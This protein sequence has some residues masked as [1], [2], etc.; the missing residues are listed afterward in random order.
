MLSSRESYLNLGYIRE[1]CF[2]RAWSGLS[3]KMPSIIGIAAVEAAAGSK[4]PW[5]VIKATT[6]L[7]GLRLISC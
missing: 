5:L 1:R 2:K 3:S 4:Q 7:G 6:H